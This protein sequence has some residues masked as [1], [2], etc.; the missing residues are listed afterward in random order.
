MYSWNFADSEQLLVVG[1]AEV[2]YIVRN[3]TRR[4]M[5]TEP[6]EERTVMHITS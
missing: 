5:N 1:A 4:E 3:E 2:Q 6:R